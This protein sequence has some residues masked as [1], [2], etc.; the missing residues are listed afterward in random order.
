MTPGQND[1]QRD[2]IPAKR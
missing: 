2:R 1:L